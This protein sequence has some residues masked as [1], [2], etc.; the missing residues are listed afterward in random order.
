MVSC[1][2]N[3]RPLEFWRLS[4]LPFIGFLLC[5]GTAQAVADLRSG[6]LTAGQ[7]MRVLGA[8][9]VSVLR[10]RTASLDINEVRSRSRAMEFEPLPR[11]LNFGYT[12]DVIWLRLVLQRQG[13]A[14]THWRLEIASPVINDVRFYAPGDSSDFAQA[15]DRYP[16]DER[17][18]AY[19]RPVFEIPLPDATPAVYYLRLQS[20]STLSGQLVLWQ[21]RAFEE[22]QQMDAL[23]IG[24]LMGTVL[25][26][27]LFFLQAWV[28]NRDK[29]LLAAA[30]VTASFAVTAMANL[31]LLSQYVLP[32]HPLLADGL[33]PA[34]MALFFPLLCL[35]FG[36][37]L[38]FAAVSRR[39][40]QMQILVPILCITAVVL[41][42]F[43]LYASLGGGLMMAGILY[44]LAWITLGAWWVWRS[45][46]RGLLTALA[47][48]ASS[49]SFAG[50]PLTA[51]GWVPA[52]RLWEVFWALGCIGFLLLAQLST[53]EEVRNV[54][55]MRR[56]AERSA[57]Q[58]R[59][60]A[61]R[62]LGWRHQQA[63]YFAGVAHDLRTPLG[64]VRAGLANLRRLLDK[65]PA[66][67]LQ[68]TE[69]LEASA[70]RASDMI[71]RHLQLQQIEQPDFELLAAPVDLARCLERVKSLAL[72]A[73]PDREFRVEATP[74]VPPSIVVDEE[75]L[76]RALTNLLANAVRASQAP[77]TIELRVRGQ[78][79]QGVYFEVH[80]GGP[81]LAPD[82]ALTDL[83][84][85]HWQRS[86]T[87]RQGASGFGIGLPMVGRIAALHGGR[88]EYRRQAQTT[89]F[90]IWLP[91][92]ATLTGLGVGSRVDPLSDSF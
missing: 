46:G 34:S 90:S 40:V 12:E 36:R 49:S 91:D 64:A 61:E 62:E 69:R 74:G 56:A 13:E 45:Q 72:E 27:M 57:R 23:W 76:L 87:T 39:L 9:E 24:A 37:A 1:F 82:K 70:L 86:Q 41:R 67:A 77:S 60:E 92:R 11:G 75:M 85:V 65:D 79:G 19:R 35:L 71:E 15:G 54:R 53:L 88:L 51:L 50:A 33:H 43:D 80:D 78:T 58:A 68:A 25:I 14:P 17:P 89:V 59:R 6:P 21:V 52:V 38:R 63:L 84:R 73:W 42:W 8:A 7:T 26:S 18:V 30:G 55:A 22:A 31:G 20:D 47:L 28:L 29:L 2:L 10:D 4:F 44:G 32:G 83:L 81:G 16:F 66:K 3:K 48:T 5:G